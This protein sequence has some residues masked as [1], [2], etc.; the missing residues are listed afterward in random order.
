MTNGIL[1]YAHNHRSV[2]YALLSVISGGL[3]KRYLNV[4]ASLVTDTPTVEWMK[5]SRIFDKAN[6][7]FENI[8][9]VDTPQTNNSR[10]LYDGDENTVVPFINSNRYSA[11]DVTPYDRTLLIDGDFLIFSDRLN[12][13]WNVDDDILIGESIN[14][15]Y[16]QKRLG[17]HDQYVSDVGIKLYWAT[18]VM[19]TKNQKTKMFFDLVSYIKN[20]YQYFADAYRFDSKQYRN[21]ISFSI[22]KH[23]IEGFEETI[24]GRLPPVLTLLDRDILYDVNNDRLTVLVSP[25]LDSTFCA[26]SLSNVDIHVMNKQSIIRNKD[27]LLELV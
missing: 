11:W 17:Y 19:F 22:A 18:T 15:I 10:R 8:I 26:A 14:D 3:A 27:K 6:T 12:E 7:V 2:D 24:T 25:Q 13:Y 23:I 20:N 1:I 4:P 9:I 16:D 5:E 21:D